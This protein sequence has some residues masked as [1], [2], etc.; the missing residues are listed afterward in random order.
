MNKRTAFLGAILSLVPLGQPLLIKTGVVLSTTVLM[1]AVPENAFAKDSD[2]YYNRAVK[3]Q[4]R[5]DYEGAIADYTKAIKINPYDQDA[6]YNRG[7]V[8]KDELKDYEGAIADY[9]KA[10][11]IVPKYLEAYINRGVVK[12]Q[13]ENY[14]GAI[15]DYT[16]AIEINYKDALAY[17]NR[18]IA[19]YKLETSNFIRYFFKGNLKSACDDWQKASYL[20]DNQSAILVKEECSSIDSGEEMKAIEELFSRKVIEKLSPCMRA[21]GKEISLECYEHVKPIYKSNK[22][23]WFDVF[24]WAR[25]KNIKEV[26]DFDEAVKRGDEIT[27]ERL[28]PIIIQKYKT[29]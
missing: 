17:A 12:D 2:Y 23:R 24:T 22:V 5:G 29:K 6:Y 4:L 15:A 18:G 25:E 10:I 3:K 14:N 16:K 9:T 28:I 1:L 21:L 19:K 11:E 26:E 8:K 7:N 13:L 20:G 27:Y